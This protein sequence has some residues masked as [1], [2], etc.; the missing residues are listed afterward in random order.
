MEP[1]FEHHA[2]ETLPVVE[3]EGVR[4]QLVLGRAY[5]ETAPASVF[6]DTFYAHVQLKPDTRI[7][8]PD[9]HEERGL[10]ILEGSVSVA[11]QS[12]EFRAD[13]GVPAQG[14]DRRRG[15]TAG[16]APHASRRRAPR[17]AASHLVEFVASSQEKIEAAKEQWRKGDWGH[18]LFDLPTGDRDEYIPLPP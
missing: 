10:Y 11:G 12:F 1:R 6:S 16:R 15:G 5:G 13:D 17:R 8:L 2:K 4:L 9:D 3:S 18:G 14:P 7:P